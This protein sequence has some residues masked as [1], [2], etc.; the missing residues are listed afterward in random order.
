MLSPP[1]SLPTM[2]PPRPFAT[3]TGT[4]Q[5]LE[6]RCPPLPQTLLEAMD[7]IERPEKLEVGPV[8]R[9][10]ERDP[11][12][13][14]RLLHIVN[15]AY[16]GLRHS[17]SSA[18][19]AVVMLGPV[20]V[21]GIVVGM[22]MLKLRMTLQGPAAEAF[23]RLTRHSVATAFITRHIMEGAPRDR[24]L[25]SQR[26]AARMG[27]SFTAGMLHDFGKIILV[28]NFPD[29]AVGFYDP[30]GLGASVKDEDPRHLEQLLFGCDHCEAGEY[31]ARKLN[32]PETLIRIIAMHHSPEEPTGDPESE[33]LRRAVV[34]ANSAAKAMGYAFSE[35]TGWDACL[36]LPELREV[37]RHDVQASVTPERLIES[38]QA[39]QEHLDQYVQHMASTTDPPPTPRIVP[40]EE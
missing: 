6:L 11:V 8:T 10:V 9:M 31:V 17:V 2:R 38:I 18:E 21:A 24:N 23:R 4:L 1:P 20:A 26:A 30:R 32:F 39:Q 37:V 5:R 40:S 19:R 27:V 28:Y 22:N 15:S 33:R 3:R 36:T 34:V 29:E 12:V 13:I 35:P 16:Y 25:S 7:L 14:A